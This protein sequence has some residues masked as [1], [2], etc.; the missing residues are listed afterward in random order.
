MEP[1]HGYT[2][3]SLARPLFSI[4]LCGGGKRSLQAIFVLETYKVLINCIINALKKHSINVSVEGMESCVLC[5]CEFDTAS[6]KKK[7]KLLYGNRCGAE[8]SILKS[9]ISNKRV[10]LSE[11]SE[12]ALRNK[13]AFLCGVCQNNLLKCKSLEDSICSKIGVNS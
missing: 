12:S 4:F 10:M 1:L 6:K 3:V 2:L 5:Q 8:L 9:I 11:I 13:N 7:W